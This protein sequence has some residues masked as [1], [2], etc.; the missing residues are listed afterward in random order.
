MFKAHRFLCF[1]SLALPLLLVAESA[2]AWVGVGPDAS[3]EVR[4]IQAAIDRIIA[5]EGQGDFV[6]PL[7]VVAGGQFNEAL[8][9]NATGIT[10]PNRAVLT[11]IGGYDA[12]CNA[13]VF[14]NTTTINAANRSAAELTISG[15]IDLSLDS[16]QL[17][18]ANTTKNGGG[19]VFGGGGTLNVT[20]VTIFGNHAGYGGGIFANGQSP[21]EITLHLP[22]LIY[23]NSADHAGG[24]IR[25]QGQAQLVM[26]DGSEIH[27]NSVNVNDL[28][29][30]G[31][32][33][34]VLS[35]ARADI[36]SAVIS[37]NSA[38]YGGGVSVN[39]S[40]AT[41][42]FG[43]GPGG[44]PTRIYSNT[45][46]NT[47]GGLF[48]S[49]G[50]AVLCGKCQINGNAAQEGAATY[51]DVNG[52]GLAINRGTVNG[53]VAR[54]LNGNAT[55]GSALLTQTN[56]GFG[57]YKTEVRGNSGGHVYRGFATGGA[58]GN[59]PAFFADI[60][61]AENQVSDNLFVMDENGEADVRRTTVANNTIGGSSIFSVPGNFTLFDS[62]IWQF[63]KTTLAGHISGDTRGLNIGDVITT[64]TA[65]LSGWHGILN[66][67]PR[68]AAPNSGD[69]HLTVFS[70]ALDY[71]GSLPDVDLDG[72][73]RTVDLPYVP[74][75]DGALD[76]GAYEL[77]AAFPPDEK[78]DEVTLPAL[79]TGWVTTHNSNNIGW[80]TVASDASGFPKAAFTEDTNLSTDKSLQTP[81][82]QVGSNAQVTFHHKVILELR[83]DGNAADGVAL[84]ISISGGAFTDIIAAGGSFV[85]GAY[86]HTKSGCSICAM[87]G[88]AVWSGTSSG[89]QSVVVNLP[90]AANGQFVRLRWR[91]GTD[92]IGGIVGG[93]YWL[94]DVHV[95]LNGFAPD[96][97]FDEVTAPA[98]PSGWINTHTGGGSDWFTVATGA[99]SFPNAAF[100]DDPPTVSDKSLTTP[101]FIVGANA[102]LRFRHKFDL[103]ASSPLSGPTF[104]GVVLEIS[105]AGVAGGQFQDIFAAGGRFVS[106]AYDHN[107]F[108]GSGNPLA[109]RSAWGGTSVGYQTVVINLPPGIGNSPIALRWRMGTDGFEAK[110]GYW[111][112]D[113]H[114]K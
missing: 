103:D 41:V 2:F 90:S 60:L 84:E 53:N 21:L 94:D 91:M 79:P 28:E 88:R 108:S 109:G 26:Q 27:N 4:T 36:N 10:G 87:D 52:G 43:T 114:V 81:A 9:I 100:T 13:P 78:F 18:G 14:G 45:A 71:S 31:G 85:S 59:G 62:I 82:F 17:T 105:I 11:I 83:N 30:A 113:I 75:R 22:T 25:I 64:E 56:A 73:P 38:K 51:V 106:G 48:V 24:G 8:R 72:F 76:L 65:S 50:A 35:P 42:I 104:D 6:D 92:F 58:S 44:P 97:T 93:G 15:V 57:I 77:Q 110:A 32:G 74:N 102:Q 29:G 47:G 46:A 1:L 96:E 37:N 70:P 20:N 95:D 107:V 101:G 61:I 7:I 99:S 68:F 5:R 49:K 89:Y 19:I 16:L 3:C 63:E 111:L 33:L 98:L 55:N 66:A 69:Y 112:D 39:G 23:N 54:T 34:Q 40:L 67:D 12:G 80:T 86:D